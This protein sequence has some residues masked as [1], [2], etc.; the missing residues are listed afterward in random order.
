MEKD[1]KN[2]MGNKLVDET[3]AEKVTADKASLER[4]TVEKAAPGEDS[5]YSGTSRKK[6][7]DRRIRRTQ[8]LLQQSLVR[9]MSEKD[10]KNISVRELSDLAD[11]NRGTFYLHYNDIYDILEQMEDELFVEFNEILDRSF[12]QDAGCHSPEAVLLDIF[13]FLER[14]RELSRVMMGPHGDRSFVNRLKELVNTRLY[15]V[16][17]QREWA[18]VYD[19]AESFVTSGCIGVIETWLYHPAP[20]SPAEMAKM[21][22]KMLVRGLDLT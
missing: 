17:A 8:T 11:I 18:C 6:P 13:S 14:H 20:R 3:A 5:G 2:N 15:H 22:S 1:R 4:N 19:Y 16:L 12:R 9:L 7:V 10:I 21:C